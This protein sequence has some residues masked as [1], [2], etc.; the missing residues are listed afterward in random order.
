MLEVEQATTKSQR[1]SKRK[2]AKIEGKNFHALI[3]IKITDS[4][5]KITDIVLYRV[6]QNKGIDK[7][8]NSGQLITLIQFFN[9]FRF[10]GSVRPFSMLYHAK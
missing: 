10:S 8:F 4:L 9:F 7:N 6:S 1:V 5:P 2:L 3:Q